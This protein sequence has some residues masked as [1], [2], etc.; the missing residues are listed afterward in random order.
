MS[1]VGKN[2]LIGLSTR[3]SHNVFDYTTHCWLI[4]DQKII[5]CTENGEIII[6]DC[7]GEYQD[8]LANSPY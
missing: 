2:V 1:M 4:C 6:L 7:N 3:L 8:I 5:V